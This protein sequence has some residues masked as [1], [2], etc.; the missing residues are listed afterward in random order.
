MTET[1]YKDFQ[2]SLPVFIRRPDGLTWNGRH[3]PKDT[4]FPWKT[5]SIDYEKAR[6]LFYASQLYHSDRLAE[7]FKA[8]DGLDMIG[9]EDLHVLVDKINGK[10]KKATGDNKA[11]FNRKKCK[12]SNIVNKQR[13]LIRSWRS[14]FGELENE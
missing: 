1:Y 8:G 11:A 9:I 13:G 4:E 2:D 14:N 5:L 12:K 3:Y 6:N 7:T 10:V